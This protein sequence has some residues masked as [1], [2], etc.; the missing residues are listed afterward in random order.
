[1]AAGENT[2]EALLKSE[3]L[4][5]PIQRTLTYFVRGSIAVHLTSYVTGLY[6]AALLIMNQIQIYKFGRIQT[7]Q[8]GG[9]RLSHPS[10]YEVSECSLPDP[11]KKI[12]PGK[13]TLP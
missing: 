2:S 10:P 12:S 5:G 9:Q 4:K 3:L 7:S 13:T 6:I 11:M 1:M 8:T